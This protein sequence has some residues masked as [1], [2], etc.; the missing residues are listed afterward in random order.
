MPALWMIRFT[1]A[2]AGKPYPTGNTAP[3]IVAAF[4]HCK[5]RLMG[6]AGT[7]HAHTLVGTGQLENFRRIIWTLLQ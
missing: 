5:G 3:P 2:L 1:F 7:H 6:A 4:K